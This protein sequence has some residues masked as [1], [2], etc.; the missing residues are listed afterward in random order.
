MGQFDA[1]SRCCS[2]SPLVFRWYGDPLSE[3]GLDL[4]VAT[5]KFISAIQNPSRIWTERIQ[6]LACA[7]FRS[8][9]K[10]ASEG[11]L[12]TYRQIKAVDIQNPPPLY[13]LRWQNIGVLEDAG[14]GNYVPKEIQVRMYHSEPGSKPKHFIGHHIHEKKI[15]DKESTNLLQDQEI[16]IAKQ[17]YFQGESTLWGL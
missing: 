2:N 17:F 11:R 4:E 6:K 3:V 5:R 12:R 9:V 7:E 8:R 1:P 13:E 14:G 10:R 16:E 15:L